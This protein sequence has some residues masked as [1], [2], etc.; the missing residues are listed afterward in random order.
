MP[1]PVRRSERNKAEALREKFVST[2]RRTDQIFALVRDP[3]LLA[4]PIVWRHPFIFYA[5][6][7][8]AFSW[9]QICANILNWPSLNSYFDDLFCRGIDP[10]VDTGECHWHPDVPDE[11]PSLAQT[12]N[13]RDKVRDAILSALE[14]L[15]T[16]GGI[17]VMARG[18]RV[19]QMVL[20]HEAM[21]QETLL[22]MMQ[23]LS[24]GEKIRPLNFARYLF[25]PTLISRPVGIGA[26]KARLGARF[27]KLAFGWD[28]EFQELIIDVPAF[29][30][31]SLPVTNGEY[32]NFLC[33]GAY[34][35]EVHWRPEDWRW[36]I[37]ENKTHPACWVKRRQGW[38]YRTMFDELPL[39][40]VSSWPVYVSLAEARAYA[41]WRGKRLPSEAE[42]HRAAYYGPDEHE[43][44]YPW[45]N[46]EPAAQHGN[47]NFASWSPIPVGSRPA[48][49]SRWG[50][51]GLVGNGWELADTPFE[52]LPGFTPY[53]TSYPDY[54]QDFFDGKHFVLKGASW[55]TDTDLLR[56]SFRN[57]YQ[58]HYPYVFAKF[59]CVSNT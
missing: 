7:L 3:K 22:Y 59:R 44:L 34:D 5:G 14:A 26:G 15:P 27:D 38:F 39:H 45:G 13:Y 11:W 6:H 17:D 28:N 12:L 9:N 29:S 31:D 1:R 36:K 47:F 37:L 49:V 56:P 21:H 16:G 8:P 48:G 42:F 41:T 55:A 10:D 35:D 30:M 46:A 4:Q 58:A 18:G 53:M 20:E 32:W 57:W 54:S 50:V 51:W 40:Q 43:T 19:F 24:F 52:P 23:Q 25:Q 2:W 33:C